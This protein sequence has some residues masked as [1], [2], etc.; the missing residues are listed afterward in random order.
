MPSIASKS[1]SCQYSLEFRQRALRLLDTTM[2]ASEAPEFEAIKSVAGQLGI[3][4]V[5]VTIGSGRRRMLCLGAKNSTKRC[6]TP[7]A[8]YG[9]KSA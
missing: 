2:E 5:R 4:E 3:S 6:L 7:R 8:Y 1:P 9:R